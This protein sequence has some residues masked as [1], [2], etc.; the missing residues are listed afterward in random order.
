M[1]EIIPNKATDSFGRL[2][3]ERIGSC[4]NL[5]THRGGNMKA[6]GIAART[7]CNVEDTMWISDIELT[8]G[9]TS[10]MTYCIT[11]TIGHASFSSIL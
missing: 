2:F 9:G 10:L 11:K 1:E 7:P 8:F 5:S 4:C 3:R 6:S